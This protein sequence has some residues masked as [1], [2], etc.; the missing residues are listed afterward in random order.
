MNVS[1]TPRLE[2]LVRMK[3]DS[4]LYSSASEV[5]REALRLMEERPES[6]VAKLEALRRDIAAGLAELEAGQGTDLD[7]EAIKAEGRRILERQSVAN[8]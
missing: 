4:G 7:I 5:V 6:R 2:A 8:D 3:V 1:L